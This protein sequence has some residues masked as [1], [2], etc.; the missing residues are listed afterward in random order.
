MEWNY[1]ELPVTIIACIEGAGFNRHKVVKIVSVGSPN[2]RF[3]IDMGLHEI[4]RAQ[5]QQLMLN[6]AFHGIISNTT[7]N[8]TLMFE[9]E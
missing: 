3:F 1:D 7:M 9:K 4:R 8:I 2:G 6:P 5:I